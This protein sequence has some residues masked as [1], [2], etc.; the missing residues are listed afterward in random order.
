MIFTKVPCE[1]HPYRSHFPL[2]PLGIFH[3]LTLECE[4]L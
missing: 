2:H 4:K 1:I 3:P